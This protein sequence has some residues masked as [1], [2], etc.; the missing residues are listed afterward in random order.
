[1]RVV[2]IT[3]T[4]FISEKDHLFEFEMHTFFRIKG[5]LYKKDKN[6]VTSRIQAFLVGAR[7]VKNS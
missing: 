5:I 1:M 7:A 6:I 2:R 4:V 3:T